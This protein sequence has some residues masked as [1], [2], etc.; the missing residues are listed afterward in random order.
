MKDMQQMTLGSM[1][2]DLNASNNF[3]FE[4]TVQA[5]MESN[6]QMLRNLYLK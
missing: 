5:G 4:A 2:M 1:A 6:F 3:A